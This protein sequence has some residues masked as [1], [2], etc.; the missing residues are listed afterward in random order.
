MTELNPE[1][2]P[3]TGTDPE[4]PE[5]GVDW[6]PFKGGGPASDAGVEVLLER[7]GALP[8]TPVSQHGGI[9]G[10]LHD[11]LMEALNEDVTGQ[12]NSMGDAAR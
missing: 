6:P 12:L 8:S 4:M 7:L 9:Y 11:D 5:A 3:A 2:D 1:M 10:N